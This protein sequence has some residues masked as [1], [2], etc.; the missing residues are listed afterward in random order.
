MTASAIA[1]VDEGTPTLDRATVGT[2]LRAW[3]T[4]RRVS[5]LELALKAG[6]SSRHISF[7]ETGRS[8]PSQSMLL[9]FAEHL[10]VPVR[11]RNALFTAAG[12]APAYPETPLDAPAMSALGQ[13][14]DLILRAH[15]PNPAL[16][17]DGMYNIVAANRGVKVLLGDLPHHLTRP[18][19]NALRLTLHPEGMASRIQNLSEWREHLLERVEGQIALRRSAALRALLE[20]V[21]AYPAPEQAPTSDHGVQAPS[22]HPYALPLRITVDGHPLS[23]IS[24]ATT[25][26]T[27]MDVTVSE[28][29]IETFLPTDPETAAALRALS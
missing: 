6:S 20:E 11:D 29:A 1:M 3:R 23:F 17:M 19:L 7:I 15:E 26:N 24:T 21:A 27:P 10:N 9:R 14:L 13:T 18:P 2:L 28:L 12:Y 8:K 5:Q 16:I 22:A 25:F 4:E